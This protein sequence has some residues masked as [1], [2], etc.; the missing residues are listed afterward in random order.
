MPEGLPWPIQPIFSGNR[1]LNGKVLIS[2]ALP[3]IRINDPLQLSWTRIFFTTDRPSQAN[4]NLEGSSN[5]FRSDDG[6][7]LAE[8]RAQ[9]KALLL[10]WLV[11]GL[12]G[13]AILSYGHY[14]LTRARASAMWPLAD[15][16]IIV[17]RVDRHTDEEG[18]H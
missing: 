4:P 16:Q 7:K 2:K 6:K 9:R 5:G 15:G 12:V 10:I 1:I 13:L 11:I 3:T 18:T 17:S 8:G 14:Q